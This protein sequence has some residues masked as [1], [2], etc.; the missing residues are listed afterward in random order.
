[1]RGEKAKKALII[2][3]DGA[4]PESIEIFMKN[5][6]LPNISKLKSMGVFARALP[7]LPTHTPV[8]WTTIGTGAWPG[9]HGIIGFAIHHRGE[10]LSKMHSGFDTREVQAEFLW[11]AAERA[12]KKCILMKW[13]GPM[14]PVTVRNGI[15]VDGCFCTE[16]IHEI[17]GP[18][19]YS[20]T[21]EPCSTRINL[22]IAEGWRGIPHSLSAPL[23]ATITVGSEKLSTELHLLLIDSKG[24]G[25]DRL[26]ISKTKDM[27]DS[28]DILKV[29]QWSRWVR[30]E[31]RGEDHATIGT[32]RLKLVELS[33]DATRLRIF[34]SQ[35]MPITGWTYPKGIDKEL[36]ENVGPFLQRV[37]YTQAG[38]IYGGWADYETFI[39][40][41]EYQHEWFAKASIYLLKKYDWDLF[42]LQSHAPDYVFDSVIKE[43]DPLTASNKEKSREYIRLIGRMYR[44]VDRMVGEIVD[45]IADEDTLIVLV[46]DHGVIAYP[47]T[48]PLP[49]IINKILVENGF[50]FYKGEGEVEEGVATKPQRIPEIDWSRTKAVFR[51]SIYIYINL[52][53]REPN[54][55]V[56]PED[57]EKVRDQIIDAL[58]SY[59]DP[60]LG[61]CPFSLVL[62][63]EDARILGLY[64]DRIGDIIVTARE[65]G[66]Y[67][68]GHGIYLPTAKYGISSL[69]ALLIMAGPGLKRN[70]ELK[71]TVW[72]TDVAPT[73][74]YLM[75]IPPPRQAEGAV[76]YE[77]LEEN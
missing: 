9:T 2:G 36:V 72:L 35:I 57:Y 68:E 51:D 53:G 60:K 14:F 11:N 38:R 52:K 23:E 39:E 45:E 12:G 50:L 18:R 16:C 46:S 41:L 55:V 49:N 20:L 7:V 73:I 28:I 31:F 32:L 64:G 48:N 19:L 70:Y 62:R 34:C 5:G 17:S 10:P 22:K 33:R 24:K 43:A 40:E 42:F 26:I 76:L 77:A 4:S 61:I 69:H 21:E 58:L 44:A 54:G 47:S 59:K 71:R 56:E 66:L 3:L 25:Y 75:D 1:M 27:K 6:E 63:A 8:N 15:Q 29:G 30:M 65:G 13:A 74:A 67:N 37:G